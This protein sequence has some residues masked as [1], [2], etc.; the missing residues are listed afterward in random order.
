MSSAYM[1]LIVNRMFVADSPVVYFV[2]A[3]ARQTSGYE[4]ALIPPFCR[5]LKSCAPLDGYRW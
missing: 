3:E 5:K 1:V 2:F 4:K